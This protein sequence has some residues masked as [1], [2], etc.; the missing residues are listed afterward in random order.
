MEE[1]SSTLKQD[2][3]IK[4]KIVELGWRFCQ[5]Y[6]GA[7]HVA[8]EMIMHTLANRYRNGWGNWLQIIDRVP[9][10]MAENELPP[11][12]HPSL[13]DATFV[14]LLQTVD[15][16]FDGSVPDKA[17]GA[18]Y[19]GDLSKIERPWF[20][21]RIVQAMKL[22]QNGCPIPAHSRVANT[23]GLCFWQ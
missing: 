17:K 12:V 16:V 1:D 19:W 10:F 8:G 23:N 11:L 2:D 15:G 14:K 5:S 20:L 13:W 6:I 4:G 7:G 3:Y 9:S 21:E 22:D 18:L